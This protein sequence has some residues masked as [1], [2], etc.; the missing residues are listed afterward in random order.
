ML[1]GPLCM[2]IVPCQ[3]SSLINIDI[4]LVPYTTL[5]FYLNL[6]FLF[7][8]AEITLTHFFIFYM[9]HSIKYLPSINKLNG[10]LFPNQW[11][12]EKAKMFQLGHCQFKL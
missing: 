3:S 1:E 5:S 11:K 7:G 12:K 4:D 10:S 2:L 6:T 8:K 9:W